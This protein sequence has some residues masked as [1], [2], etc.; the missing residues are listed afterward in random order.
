VWRHTTSP[1]GPL[2]VVAS[3]ATASLAGHSLIVQVLCFRA[4][5]L[6]GVG[7]L[8]V[9]LPALARG[10]GVEP[11]Q[12]L[13]LGVLSPLALFSAVS[14]AHND[15]LMIGLLVLGLVLARRGA[16]RAALVVIALAATVKLPALAGAV[17][18]V[19][20]AWRAASGRARAW[21][22]VE[23]AVLCGVVVVGVTLLNAD[24]WTWLGSHA[25]SIPTQL[26]VLTTPVVSVGALL[27][28]GLHA[29]GDHV[30]T[31]DVVTWSQHVGEVLA[32]GGI[33]VL[34]LRT[35]ADNAVRS[36]GVA[37]LLLVLASPTLW[38]WYLLW[39]LTVLA[40]T[41]AQRSAFLALCAG[42]AMLLVGPGGTPMIGGNGVYVSGPLVLAA[43]AWFIW[44]GT[45]RTV[46]N[47][48]DRGH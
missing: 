32:L 36:L 18:I 47:G 16:R 17:F 33:V 4:L 45:W 11:G 12:A 13:W 22:A 28:S 24:G 42:A 8:M 41:G 37:L 19:G 14:S 26:H 1:Y 21:L 35:R 7:L 9:A 10:L 3:R 27:A 23:S 15:T 29:L 5:E 43:L 46:V 25:L 31:R 44:S 2:F 39:G 30:A 48:V 6:I 38:P 34:V 20:P 40:A